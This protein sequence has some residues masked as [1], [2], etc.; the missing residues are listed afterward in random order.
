MRSIRWTLVFVG[1]CSAT[2]AMAQRGDH[3]ETIRQLE[4]M[5]LSTRVEQRC[6]ERATGAT[7]REGKLHSPEEVI[8]YAFEDDKVE[9]SNVVA[10][11]AA[12]KDGDRWYRMQYSCTTSEDG[13]KIV[14][15]QYKLG[16]E[17]PRQEWRKYHLSP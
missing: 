9:G 11:G 3:E 14:N 12:I 16:H 10:P 7:R 15:F 2:T 4:R 5:E 17:V 6:N 8:A 13:L 1:A